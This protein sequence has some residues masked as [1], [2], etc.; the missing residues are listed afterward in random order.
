MQERQQQIPHLQYLTIKVYEF[1]QF[2]SFPTTYASLNRSP[3]YVQ[4]E[5]AKTSHLTQGSMRK[6]N[7]SMRPETNGKG[8][9][10]TY[11]EQ[12]NVCD[13]GSN[14]ELE[15]NKIERKTGK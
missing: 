3:V 1:A 8:R 6:P 15:D 13:N 7:W 11:P 9:G 5:H 10:L 12:T 4:E 14:T 2:I